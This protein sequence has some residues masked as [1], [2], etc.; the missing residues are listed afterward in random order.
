MRIEIDEL[1]RRFVWLSVGT[2]VLAAVAIGYSVQEIG[3]HLPDNTA[4]VDPGAVAR[5]E[6]PPFD[7]PGLRQV[8]ENRYEAVIVSRAFAFDTGETMVVQDAATEE[9][10]EIGVLRVP[11]GA[12]I[13]FIATAQDVIHGMRILDSNVNVM[14]IPGEVTRATHTFEEPGTLQLLCME[15]CGIGHNKMYAEVIVE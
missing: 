12:T 11:Q 1:E 15:Y 10:I 3:I 4:T 13:D 7:E 2:L 14:L 5:G 8:G 6:A 9:D